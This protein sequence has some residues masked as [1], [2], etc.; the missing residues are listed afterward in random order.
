LNAVREMLEA[1]GGELFM[2]EPSGH[3]TAFQLRF[4]VL[5]AGLAGIAAADLID[6]AAGGVQADRPPSGSPIA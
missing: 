3:G 6:G 1:Q 5:R 2:D 4:P